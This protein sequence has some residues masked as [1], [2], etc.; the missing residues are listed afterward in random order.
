ML[1]RPRLKVAHDSRDR[2]VG[3]ARHEQKRGTGTPPEASHAWKRAGRVGERFRLGENKG[4]KPQYS[5]QP[6]RM[7]PVKEAGRQARYLVVRL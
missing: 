2:R 3:I 4:V 6:F 1:E 5:H 7:A